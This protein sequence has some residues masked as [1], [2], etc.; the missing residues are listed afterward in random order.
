MKRIRVHKDCD[1]GDWVLCRLL[2][3]IRGDQNG[4]IYEYVIRFPQREP[5]SLST[6]LSRYRHMLLE[7][8]GIFPSYGLVRVN[9]MG[10]LDTS[11]VQYLY[12][13]ERNDYGTR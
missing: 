13:C 7:R 4:R 1:R 11:V 5:T 10:K 9:A 6:G 8:E 12:N 2:R 3:D